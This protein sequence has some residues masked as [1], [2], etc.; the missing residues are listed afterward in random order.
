VA[1]AEEPHPCRDPPS[2][3]TL[4]PG[5][6]IGRP[7]APGSAV[8]GA[9][10]CQGRPSRSLVPG[11]PSVGGRPARSGWPCHRAAPET[12]PPAPLGSCARTGS[13]RAPLGRRPRSSGAPRAG[14]LRRRGTPGKEH[15]GKGSRRRGS[16]PADGR[17]RRRKRESHRRE[18]IWVV[19]FGP[20]GM[21]SGKGILGS[22]Q[23]CWV[24]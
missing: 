13:R 6:A 10:R 21:G 4:A 11:A 9:P 15:A 2:G 17:A 18:K 12:G 23:I 14:E 19:R 20:T 8:E 16:P 3:A 1:R 7:A 24:K 5:S 22:Q